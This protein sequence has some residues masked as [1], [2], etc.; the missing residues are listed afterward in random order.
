MYADD[1]AKIIYNVI[2]NEIYE[3]FNVAGEENLSI[4]EMV[5]IAI[6][7][8]DAQHLKIKWDIDKPNGQHR[9]DVSIEKLKSLLPNFSSLKL[10]EG[11]KLVYKSYYDKISK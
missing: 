8:C 9:K 3:S 2:V 11:I 4:K 7:S 10:S 1:F 6:K 5:D